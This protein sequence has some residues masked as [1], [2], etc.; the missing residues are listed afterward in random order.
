MNAG[1]RPSLR[2]FALAVDDGLGAKEQRFQGACEVRE[3]AGR[4]STRTPR[5]GSRAGGDDLH[6]VR[7][8]PGHAARLDLPRAVVYQW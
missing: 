5:D 1:P 6:G 2:R 8:A 3:E 7:D 4:R